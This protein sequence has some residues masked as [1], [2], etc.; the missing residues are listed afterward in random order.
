[1]DIQGEKTV[2]TGV[3]N[4]MISEFLAANSEGKIISKQEF[5]A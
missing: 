3:E 4:R 1:M 2:S 5:N